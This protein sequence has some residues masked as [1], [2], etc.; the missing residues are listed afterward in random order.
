MVSDFNPEKYKEDRWPGM[1]ACPACWLMG[2]NEETY[3]SVQK[4]KNIVQGRLEQPRQ[5]KNVLGRLSY[6]L[7]HLPQF[8]K[9]AGAT[10][11]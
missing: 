9:S 3:C 7:P 1:T 2:T 11:L 4:G 10:T 5:D 8:Q 6:V